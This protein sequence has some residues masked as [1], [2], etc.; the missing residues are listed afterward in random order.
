ML[1]SF[2]VKKKALIPWIIRIMDKY[3]KGYTFYQ[4]IE[5]SQ[6]INLD[7]MDYFSQCKG[8]LHCLCN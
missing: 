6:L 1:I 4:I 8:W 5:P 7:L 2:D 3:K